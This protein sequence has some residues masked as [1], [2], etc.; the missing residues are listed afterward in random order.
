MIPPPKENWL[1]GHLVFWEW[2][3]HLP[4]LTYF[5]KILSMRSLQILQVSLELKSEQ[6]SSVLKMISQLLKAQILL[7]NPHNLQAWCC[8]VY[9]NKNE[10]SANS[11]SLDSHTLCSCTCTGVAVPG[12]ELVIFVSSSVGRTVV[13]NPQREMFIRA[14]EQ[15]SVGFR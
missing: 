3:P 8:V 4:S 2:K 13:S 11:E 5:S 9:I 12:L 1:T 15:N 14:R 7:T 6:V 10:S